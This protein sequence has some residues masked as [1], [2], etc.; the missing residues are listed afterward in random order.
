[1][2]DDIGHRVIVIDL[3]TSKAERKAERY[4]RRLD[5]ILGKKHKTEIEIITKNKNIRSLPPAKLPNMLPSKQ[6]R[7]ALPPMGDW[8]FPALPPY[9]KSKVE[10][11]GGKKSKVELLEDEESNKSGSIS[12]KLDKLVKIMSKFTNFYIR[13]SKSG[14]RGG[15]SGI[16]PITYFKEAFKSDAF[17]N[18]DMGK[19]IMGIFGG[20]TTAA[21]GTVTG[22]T[23]AGMGGI[24]GTIATI[25]GAGATIGTAL[26]LTGAAATA[27]GVGII[28][29][30]VLGILA[31]LALILAAILAVVA[32]T[33][34]LAKAIMNSEPFKFLKD[35]FQ[36][37]IGSLMALI[38]FPIIL[39]TE[40]WNK[41]KEFTFDM[42]DWLKSFI[43]IPDTIGEWIMS[44]FT[45]N[46]SIT[47][48]INK[49]LDTNTAIIDWIK[50]NIVEPLFGD[51][52][53]DQLGSA[54][55]LIDFI[56]R[57]L[58]GEDTSIIDFIRNQLD[59]SNGMPVLDYITGQFSADDMSINSWLVGQ[60]D[61]KSTFIYSWM[62]GQFTAEDTSIYDWMTGQ[63]KGKQPVYDWIKEQVEKA[64]DITIEGVENLSD[65]AKSAIDKFE[66]DT[67]IDIPFV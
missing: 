17:K 6:S 11:I 43:D 31:I 29:G 38:F 60:F 26:G 41:I 45:D 51:W 27:T 54:T 19:A 24:S 62:T 37:F 33:A 8:S 32:A 7:E 35:L 34:A 40:V 28:V 66:E 47:D 3:D 59:L 22:G 30:V 23:V 67:G 10:V 53:R 16:N 56:H 21:G 48:W 57:N 15:W 18:S 12:E 55:D 20:T 46:T 42:V 1:L 64:K 14:V 13:F 2:A 61:P 58:T 36:G 49:A 50:D 5:R 63:F 25:G 4:D 9:K 44:S 52:I 65:D 39:M